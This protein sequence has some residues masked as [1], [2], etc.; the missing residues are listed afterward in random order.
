MRSQ[1]PCSAWAEKIALRRE[2]LSPVERAAL[3]AHI[4]T[5]PACKVTQADY[6]FLDSRLRQ[7]PPPTLRPLPRLSVEA[8]MQDKEDGGTE[9]LANASSVAN[10][11][12]L[13]LPIRRKA[14]RAHLLYSLKRSFPAAFV[15]CLIL[16][17]L[18]FFRFLIVSNT[19]SQPP[20]TAILTYKGHSDYVDAVAWSPNGQFI[21]SGS[22]D[23]TVQVWDAY[24]GA[25]ITT[26]KGHTDNVSALAWSPDGNFIASGSWDGYVRVWDAFTGSLQ[27]IYGGH[28]DAVSTL[29]W[30]PNG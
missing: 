8:F 23:G 14:P 19:S 10:S 15:A 11:T 30:S 13:S 18:L 16:A 6:D 28:S 29:A 24:S 21:A 27:T 7:L 12:R 2:D 1:P 20:G 9:K 5:C 26:Y 22:W 25:V 4:Q 3:D 17:F